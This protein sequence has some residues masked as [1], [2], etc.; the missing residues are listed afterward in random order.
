M[1]NLTQVE[2]GRYRVVSGELRFEINK[3]TGGG[4]TILGIGSAATTLLTRLKARG[5]YGTL[6][7][8]KSLLTDL[9]ELPAIKVLQ[10][11]LKTRPGEKGEFDIT[12]ID[13][14]DLKNIALALRD[15]NF[16]TYISSGKLAVQR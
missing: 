6:K 9:L 10:A 5:T 3:V 16:S 8:A 2:A 14:D 12:G 15:M 13:Q 1:M 7:G 4:W 11:A